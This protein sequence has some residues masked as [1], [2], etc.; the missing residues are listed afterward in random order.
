MAELKISESTKIIIDQYQSEIKSAE[1]ALSIAKKAANDILNVILHEAHINPNH[2]KNL[3]ILDD[4]FSFD[5]KDPMDDYQEI[6]T[7]DKKIDF[8]HIVDFK[9]GDNVKD[10]GI[11]SEEIEE[12][13]NNIPND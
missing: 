6:S 10:L 12:A 3:Q 5:L 4:H 1:V 7:E 13:I 8:K 9:Q 11:D 2:I